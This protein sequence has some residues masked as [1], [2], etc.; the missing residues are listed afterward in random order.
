MKVA[1]VTGAN[2]VRS[3]LVLSSICM[4]TSKQG[5][6]LEIAKKIGASGFKTILACRSE[7]LGKE[8]E[9]NLKSLGYDVEYRQ[10]DVGEPSGF[11]SF[12]A[13]LERDYGKV[14]VLVNNAA[15]A[16]LADSQVP[17][18]EQARRT[19]AINF[20]G[21]LVLT[22]TLLPLLRKSNSPRI[23]NV[24]SSLGKLSV[25]KE[26]ATKEKYAS[27][28]TSLTLSE[29][30]ELVNKFFSDIDA[31]KIT[32]ASF[33]YSTYCMSKV[34]LIAATKILARQE[35][36]I[37]IN[38]CCP[39]YCATDLNAHKGRDIDILVV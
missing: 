34:A 11:A 7:P 29:L 16:F 39:G 26:L 32:E 13:G 37:L 25:V 33:P 1:V 17:L 24:A 14:D 12:A 35:P 27:A 5:I 8:A 30:E 20:S 10:L 19:F 21:T 4:Q 28:E 38:A 2:K 31:G 18:P 6:G 9:Q 23:V 36:K 22:Q 3:Y 15:I